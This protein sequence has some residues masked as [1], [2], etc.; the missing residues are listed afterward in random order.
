MGLGGDGDGD[1]EGDGVDK[2]HL[3]HSTLPSSSSSSIEPLK[4]S[5]KRTGNLW[6]AFAHIITALVG[7][8]VLSL[9][10]SIAQLGWIAGPLSVLFFASIALISAFLV[11]NCYKS[12]DSDNGPTRN[13]SF[14]E[15]VQM[16]LGKRSAS[17]CSILI[18]LSMFK[19]GIVYTITSGIS[20]RAIQKSNC[21]H[22]EGREAACEYGTT[23]YMLLFGIIQIIPDFHNMGWLSTVATIMSFCYA[24][25]GSALGLAKNGYIKG[26]IVG[27]STST[28]TQ[29][30][31][32]KSPPSEKVTM[33]KASVTATCITT[34]FYICCGGFGYAAFGNS[35]PGNLLTG[36]GFYEPYWLIDFANVCVSVH[37][38]GSYLLYSQPVFAIVE[39][40]AAEKY[41]NS[42]F[43]NNNYILKIP[44][45]P[46]FRSNLFRLCFRTTYVAST[47]SVAI[48][49][50]YF[51]QV[52]GVAGTLTAWPLDIYF[53]VEMYITQKNVGRWTRKWI[54]Y[55]L[56][57]DNVRLDRISWRTYKCKIQLSCWDLR[58]KKKKIR[59][60]HTIWLLFDL[61]SHHKCKNYLIN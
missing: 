30:D 16:I 32:L 29:K 59:P 49:F 39:R 27:V 2:T 38:V 54:Y 21:Y 1:G 48:I 26:D 8:G 47:T 45:L 4:P 52:L 51:N 11:T 61:R 43:V 6:T 46:A 19:G 15:A 17:L 42:G 36:F 24:I 60:N 34:I 50:P 35:A 20:M 53:P 23:S 44:L 9:A 10:W 40:W 22:K 14:L 3:L 28:A 41:P 57:S 25:I 12:P 58:K 56:A 13:R 7:S 18:R 33:K 5:L 37:L 55:L 31:T